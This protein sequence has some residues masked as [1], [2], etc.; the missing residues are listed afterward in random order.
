VIALWL[1]LGALAGAAVTALVLSGRLSALRA[2]LSEA[3]LELA[4]A[5]AEAERGAERRVDHLLSGVGEALDRVNRKLEDVERERIRA[6]TQLTGAIDQLRAS[7]DQILAGTDA[8][9]GALRRPHVRG[10]WGEITLRNVVE[11]AGMLAHV[12]FDE[13]PTL[14]GEEGRLR[15]DACVHLPGGR[16][17]VIDA[18]TPFEAYLQACAT[19]EP[20]ERAALMRDHARQ[21][22]RHLSELDSKAY[23]ERLPRSPDFVVMFI[24]NDAVLMAAMEADRSLAEQINS[25]RVVVAT[26]M[27]LMA[28][29][30]IVALGW[31]QEKLADSAHEIERLGRELHRRLAGFAAKLDTLGRRLGTA[32]NG[33]NEVAGA[34]ERSVLPSARRMGRL[35]VAPGGDEV[36]DAGPVTVM[37]RELRVPDVEGVVE[38]PA[39]R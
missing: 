16:D 9:V 17:V 6:S 32:V 29:L 21:L 15:P 19:T 14:P 5:R 18:K 24:P 11:S 35:G 23:W 37:P 13:Q 26:P 39:V 34:F 2:A 31:R 36:P 25:R 30:R 8:L 22:R 3:R 38:L 4:N 7:H 33:Y 12:D 1:L 10:R 28:L 27:N 20:E